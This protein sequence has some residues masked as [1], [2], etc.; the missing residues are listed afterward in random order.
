[1]QGS[2]DSG[3]L[4]SVPLGYQERRI[5]HLHEEIDRRIGAE[6]PDALRVE[7]LLSDHVERNAE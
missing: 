3:A 2:I 5:Y 6:V 7:P 1:M 4:E